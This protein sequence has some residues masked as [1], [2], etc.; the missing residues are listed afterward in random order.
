MTAALRTRSGPTPTTRNLAR[1]F[2]F[3][4]HDAT[5]GVVHQVVGLDP[6]CAAALHHVGAAPVESVG[7]LAGRLGRTHSATV[8]AVDRL[9][10]EG[11]VERV[12]DGGDG[13][14]VRLRLTRKG[15]ARY[16]LVRD[17]ADVEVE[18][19]LAGLSPAELETL[20]RLLAGVVGRRTRRH[21]GHDL[22]CRL[23]DVTACR[24]RACPGRSPRGPA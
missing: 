11:L 5:L 3:L 22:A 21:R 16:G 4:L 19:L 2:A 12:R 6:T 8:R 13:R 14:R 20:T 9:V 1:A 18:D 15:E 10:R 17:A 24:A 23:C 7:E